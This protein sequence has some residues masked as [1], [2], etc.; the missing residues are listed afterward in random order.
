MPSIRVV[1][2]PSGIAEQ[3]R[4]TMTAPGYGHPAYQEIAKGTGPCRHCLGWTKIGEEERI[5][6]TYDPFQEVGTRALPG[7][8]F[9]HKAECE[10]H[11]ED[12][13]FPENL[14]ELK[15]T[16]IAFGA[17]RQVCAEEQV[18]DGQVEASAERLFARSEV[19]YLHVRFTEPGC[20][21]LR[22]ERGAE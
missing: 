16:L 9:V 13:G 2:L 14:R 1:A 7:P 21:G 11:D 17:D 19:K 6:F 18:W 8:I 15:L 20:Y 22:I 12:A 4:A 3:V 5:L 10:R